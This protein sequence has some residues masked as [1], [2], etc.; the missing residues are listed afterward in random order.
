MSGASEALPRPVLRR[1]AA[2]ALRVLL[3]L[4]LQAAQAPAVLADGGPAGPSFRVFDDAV[5]PMAS[6]YARYGGAALLGPPVSRR[7]LWD[8]FVCQA[9]QK[10]VL[11]WRPELGYAL[12]VNVLDEL[13][14]RGKDDYLASLGVPRHHPPKD[15]A[16]ALSR[17]DPVPELKAYILSTPDWKVRFGLP[18]AAGLRSDFQVVRLQRAVLQRWLIKTPWADPGEITLANIGDMLK[19]AGLIPREALEPEAAPAPPPAAGTGWLE[20]L[21][22]YRGLVGLP[23]AAEDPPLSSGAA[24]HAR[25]MVLT[26]TFEHREDPTNPHYTPEGDRA[27]RS[28]NIFWATDPNLADPEAVDG[29]MNSPGHALWILNPALKRVGFG[30]FRDPT[31]PGGWK[32]AAT[33]EVLSG[34]EPPPPVNLPILWPRQRA[35]GVVNYDPTGRYCPSSGGQMAVWVAVVHRQGEAVANAAVSWNGQPLEAAVWPYGPAGYGL[36]QTAVFACQDWPR[37]GSYRFEF[38]VGGRP[39]ALEFQLRGP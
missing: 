11:Q 25:Y 35:D 39:A 29:W 19:G 6:E 17:L 31:A 7:F 16:E 36:Y 15:E 9:F 10:G 30:S 13:A 32:Y 4:F 27:A 37:P 24:L 2:R 26:Q 12:P 8:G 18:I 5:A 33:L 23:P 38:T 34:R 28:S 1:G 14:R 22:Y 20:R 21:N 3:I